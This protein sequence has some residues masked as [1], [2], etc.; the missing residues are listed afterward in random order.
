MSESPRV[1]QSHVQQSP[2]TVCFPFTGDRIGGSHISAMK[3]ILALDKQ[4]YNPLVLV[5]E[6]HGA[7]ARLFRDNGLA[8]EPVPNAP[9]KGGSKLKELLK[10][11][12]YARFLKERQ[13]GIVH[14]NDGNTH[15]IWALPAKLAGAAF[16]WHHRANP[17]AKGLT[18]L[19]PAVADAVIAVSQFASPKPGIW[20]AAKRSVVIHSPFDTDIPFLDREACHREACRELQV[21]AETRI[22]GFFG[23]LVP[24]KRP[25]MFVDAIAALLRQSPAQ[26]VLGLFFGQPRGGLDGAVSAR[27]QE[28]GVADNIRIMGFKSPF[29]PWIAATDA[30]LV[31][32]VDEPFGRTLIEAMTL[33]TPVV[34]TASG[35]NIEA[36]KDGETGFLVPLDDANA[37]ADRLSQLLLDPALHQ[38]IGTAAREDVLR[39][40]S[41]QQHAEAVMAVYDRIMRARRPRLARSHRTPASAQSHG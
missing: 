11:R 31:P 7:V 15:T 6:P 8:F 20:S 32:A 25:V 12:L 33:G 38:R 28:L 1:T 10:A 2:L 37:M 14:T 9:P 36:I 29:E 30:L 40:F 41:V 19:A 34:A 18:L 13:V 4:R 21:P 16:V 39:R 3:L 22:V 27:A 24:R 17:K 35:G 26:P 23:N 5:H